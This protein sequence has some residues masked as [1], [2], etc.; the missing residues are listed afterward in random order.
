MIIADNRKIKR[1]NKERREIADLIVGFGA[2]YDLLSNHEKAAHL[3]KKAYE[4]HGDPEILDCCLSSSTL[5]LNSLEDS[6]EK[7][8]KERKQALENIE[9]LFGLGAR[10]N[11]FLERDIISY[12]YNLGYNRN[13]NN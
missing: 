6:E 1:L 2:K 8:S 3:Y 7:E 13:A 4:M 10:D 9:D 12:L 11:W 5:L